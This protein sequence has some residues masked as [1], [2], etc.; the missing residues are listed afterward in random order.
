M[1]EEDHLRVISM[2]KGGNMKEVFRR[3]CVGLQKVGLSPWLLTPGSA[4][5]RHAHHPEIPAQTSPRSR[6]KAH[7]TSCSS[8]AHLAPFHAPAPPTSPSS[9]H[10]FH[11]YAHRPSQLHPLP[12]WLHP[13]RTPTRTPPTQTPPTYGSTLCPAH[14][15]GSTHSLPRLHPHQ[16]RLPWLHPHRS[17]PL[18]VPVSCSP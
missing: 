16:P 15:S 8:H 14:R 9:T 6:P 12:C 11:G 17:R 13:M 18:M 2:E 5:K 1:N 10:P 7:P 4:P 3:F